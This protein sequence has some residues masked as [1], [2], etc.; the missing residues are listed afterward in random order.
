MP[1]E[2][3]EVIVENLRAAVYATSHEEISVLVQA[4]GGLDSKLLG[5]AFAEVRSATMPFMNTKP[6]PLP[7]PSDVPRTKIPTGPSVESWRELF[8]LRGFPWPMKLKRR[9]VTPSTPVSSNSAGP[10]SHA[11]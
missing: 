7:P 2:M 3:S 1:E 11:S 6:P 10:D 4:D 5:T 9:S 8:S